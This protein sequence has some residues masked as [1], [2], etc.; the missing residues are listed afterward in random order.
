MGRSAHSSENVSRLVYVNQGWF[1]QP[2]IKL[3]PQLCCRSLHLCCRVKI[4]ISFRFMGNLSMSPNYAHL[5]SSCRD[6]CL[7]RRECS[8]LFHI[9]LFL[10]ISDLGR[11]RCT[12]HGTEAEII[13][14][15]RA[16]SQKSNEYDL[17]DVIKLSF[18][19][20]RFFVSLFTSSSSAH[21]LAFSHYTCRCL[22]RLWLL[23]DDLITFR[24]VLH[25]LNP[26]E[27]DS[28]NQLAASSDVVIVSLPL[29]HPN[30]LYT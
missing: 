29:A 8:I 3:L 13:L 16:R 1:H 27:T 2:K 15:N 26:R 4:S 20:F 25:R 11:R 9:V 17:D 28:A 30:L 7:I 18:I 5:S 24:M 22:S 23:A 21:N 10:V 12:S 6:V 14:R 19:S